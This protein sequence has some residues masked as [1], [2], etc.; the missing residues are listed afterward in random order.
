MAVL[1]LIKHPNKILTKPCTPVEVFDEQIQQFCKDLQDSVR[2]YEGLGLAAPQVGESLR[3][4]A[5]RLSILELPES[6]EHE[7]ALQSAEPLIF[8]NPRITSSAGEDSYPEACLSIPGL[9]TKVKRASY[10]VVEAEDVEGN[11]F[12]LELTRHQASVVQ[13]EMDH[14]DGK[15]LFHRMS[16]LQLRKFHKDAKRKARAKK[17]FAKM[18]W[19]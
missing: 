6:Q 15:L 5:T 12:E 4:F 7:D 16:G 1:P 10:I 3:I 18:Q 8:I 19:A 13:H 11:T 2:F 14:L 9:Q 17:R